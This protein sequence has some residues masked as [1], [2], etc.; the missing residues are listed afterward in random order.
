MLCNGFQ[1]KMNTSLDSRITSIL[2]KFKDAWIANSNEQ[3][4]SLT[5]L[6]FKDLVHKSKTVFLQSCDLDSDGGRTLFSI[7]IK[8]INTGCPELVSSSFKFFVKCFGQI[9]ETLTSLS[10]V[11][12][13]IQF[14]FQRTNYKGV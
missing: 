8:L 4:D 1:Y 11:V 9:K 3:T 2:S 13:S 6:S 12:H 14:F 5:S 7:L 10:Q